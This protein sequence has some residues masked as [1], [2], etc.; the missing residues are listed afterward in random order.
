MKQVEIIKKDLYPLINWD[1]ERILCFY[2]GWIT[3][4]DKRTCRL[5]KIV[6]MPNSRIR[7]LFIYSRILRRR[8][9][10]YE[11]KATKIN[12]EIVFLW[13]HG[14]FYLLNIDSKQLSVVANTHKTSTNSVLYLTSTTLGPLWGDYGYNPYKKSRSIYRYNVSTSCIELLYSFPEG[15]INHIHNIIEDPKSGRVWIM[16]GDFGDSAAIYYTDDFFKSLIC[17]AKGNQNYRSCFG[18]SFNNTLY[19]MTDTPFCENHIVQLK[20][21]RFKILY[22]IKGSCIYA[23]LQG[24]R[25]IGSTTVENETNEMNNSVNN[26]KYN[27][28][29]GI[30]DWSVDVFSFDMNTEFYEVL[31]TVKKDILPMMPF[32]YGCFRFPENHVDNNELYCYGQAVRRYKHKLIKICL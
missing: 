10:L 22:T 3:F 26:F 31:C 6:L 17:V 13:Y 27:L 30:K 7:S 4:F 25:I 8:F 19:F 15:E 11:I 2:L 28:G 24:S 21:G 29:K 5:S 18:V 20:D 14:V 12:E 1:N 16:T 32:G 9:G 23:M